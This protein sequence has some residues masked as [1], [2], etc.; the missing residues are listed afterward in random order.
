MFSKKGSALLLQPIAKAN[1]KKDSSKRDRQNTQV[2]RK[3][4]SKYPL[5]DGRVMRYK[6]NEMISI[7]T[8]PTT[9]VCP[10]KIRV[11]HNVRGQQPLLCPF[12]L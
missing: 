12:T 9:C 4:S 5:Q 11:N 6:W 3:F 8:N 1:Y 10:F 7:Y 2:G